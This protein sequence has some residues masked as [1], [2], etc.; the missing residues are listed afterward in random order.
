MLPWAWLDNDQN[1]IVW[2]MGWILTRD[3]LSVSRSVTV[4]LLAIYVDTDKEPD[5]GFKSLSM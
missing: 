1:R 4:S 5:S 3:S 2:M